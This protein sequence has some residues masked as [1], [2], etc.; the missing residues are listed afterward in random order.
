MSRVIK[1]VTI[2][3]KIQS[4]MLKWEYRCNCLRHWMSHLRRY[5][6]PIG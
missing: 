1:L 4:D 5:Y 3:K 2:D 6:S